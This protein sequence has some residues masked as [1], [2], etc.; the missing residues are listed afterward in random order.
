MGLFSKDE[1]KNVQAGTA[2]LKNGIRMLKEAKAQKAGEEVD[3]EVLNEQPQAAE[4][5]KE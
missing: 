1:K 5:Q 3:E 2:M 4:E